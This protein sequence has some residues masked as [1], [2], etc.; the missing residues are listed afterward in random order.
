MLTEQELDRFISFITE[1]TGIIP[2]ETHRRSIGKFVDKC[3]E[4]I[5][6]FAP[7]DK[8]MELL[9]SDESELAALVNSSTVNETY[10]FR[11]K[12]QFTVLRDSI[13]PQWKLQNI[14]RPI[15]LWS[16]DEHTGEE[17]Y[18]LVLLAKSLGL[19]P[20][21][22]VSDIDTSVLKRC[23]H[24]EFGKHSIRL[25]DGTEFRYLLD[26]YIQ[27]DETVVFPK[28]I[29]SLLKIKQINLAKMHLPENAILLPKNQDI[30]FIRNVFIYFS[31]EMRE[32]I[33]QV[34]T[35]KCLAPNGYLFVSMSETATLD[36]TITPSN[37]EK[38]NDGFVYYFKKKA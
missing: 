37:L 4:N 6:S 13:L 28:E 26:P 23:N 11:E 19:N 33:L 1:R 3:L 21:M 32:Q 24:G 18:S 8:Y 14:G 15:R 22:T 10:F 17:A 35:E 38:L 2:L 25:H 30:I 7:Q 27:Q 16:E 31:Q 12:Q 29:T 9:L 5:E 20:D 34:L 36:E